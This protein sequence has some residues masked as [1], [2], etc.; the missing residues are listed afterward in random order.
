M[1]ANKK[2]FTL[3]E[4]MIVVAI[5]GILAAIAIPKFADLIRKSNEGATK[6]NLGSVRS[7]V[8]IYYGEMEG[9]YPGGWAY[10]TTKYLDVIPEAKNYYHGN[11]S[12]FTAPATVMPDVSGWYYQSG[13]GVVLVSCTHTDTKNLVIST[14]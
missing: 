8:S 5:I 13:N 4:L 2:G 7:A 10:L 12:A 3:I 1:K 11:S 14:W 6:G 9:S